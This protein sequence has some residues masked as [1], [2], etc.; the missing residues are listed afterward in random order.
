MPPV[1][2][3]D[4]G[5]ALAALLDPST[6]CSVIADGIHVHPAL[7]RLLFAA[8][9]DRTILVSDAMPPTGTEL[10]SFMLQGRVIHRAEGSL[11]T[12]DNVL[13]GTDICLADAVRFCVRQM[14]LPPEQAI[15]MA[16]AAPADFLR[17]RQKIGRIAPG[18]R[19]DLVLFG[20]DLDVLGTWV[21]GDF[22]G[23]PA[24]ARAA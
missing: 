4:P 12:A 22:Q 21:G 13:A 5:I 2:A 9:P 16:T 10:A 8:K 3:R 18:L 14:G 7:L 6:Y 1:A 23:D 24:V 11:R 15:G 20:A 19:A 17:V